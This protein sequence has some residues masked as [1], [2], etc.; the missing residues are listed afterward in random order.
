[1]PF[2]V[3]AGEGL[4][5]TGVVDVRAD[6][7]RYQV[8]RA[9]RLVKEGMTDILAEWHGDGD[10]EGDKHVAFL[11]GCSF[12]FDTALFAAGVPPRRMVHGGNVP[13]YRTSIPL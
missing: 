5:G 10:E 8:Y 3:C 4:F 12:G 6:L 1:M 7:P 13:M 9:G 11:I 2:P